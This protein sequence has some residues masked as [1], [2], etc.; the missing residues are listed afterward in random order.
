MSTVAVPPLFPE[1][2]LEDDDDELDPEL[3]LPH[4]APSS[5]ASA[6]GLLSLLCT[7][8]PPTF[9]GPSPSPGPPG[10]RDLTSCRATSRR[11]TRRCPAPLGGCVSCVATRPS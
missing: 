2:A 4:A 9:T 5:A 6:T 7:I 1:L 11:R 8:I 3:L 10:A